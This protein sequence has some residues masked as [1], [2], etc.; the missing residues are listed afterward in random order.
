MEALNLKSDIRGRAEEH[1][2]NYSR[3][4]DGEL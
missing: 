2:S 4:W 1:C 3:L